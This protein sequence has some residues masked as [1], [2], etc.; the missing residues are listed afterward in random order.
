MKMS[1]IGDPIRINRK[2]AQSRILMPPLV[3]FQWADEEGFE[4]ESREEHYGRRADAKVG[5]IVVEATAICKEGRITNTEL[6][7]WREEHIPQFQRIAESCHKGGALVLVQLVHAGAKASSDVVYSPSQQEVEGKCC[8]ALSEEEIKEV[9]LQFVEA[10]KRAYQ[11]GLDGVEIHGAHGYLLNQFTS[12]KTNKR[13]DRYGGN[14]DNRLRLPLEI[15]EEIR[16]NTD[17]RFIIGYRFGVNDLSFSEDIYFAKTLEENGVDILDVS[18]GIGVSQMEAPENFPF[19][20]ITYMGTV[21]KKHVRIPVA[22]VYGILEP[23]QAEE[24]LKQNLT[25]MVAVGRALLADPQWVEKAID[26][27]PVNGCYQCKPRCKYAE[28]GNLCPWRKKEQ[29]NQ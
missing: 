28:N 17:P 15:V 12:S 13:E 5:V 4:T 18:S 8:K 20:P 19:S 23:S 9:K 7:L 6:G 26:K 27:V 14:L 2:V 25:D 29:S 16:K 21:I 3:C 11:A 1:E 10:A 24:L 22:S